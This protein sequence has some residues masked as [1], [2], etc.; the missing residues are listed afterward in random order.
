MLKKIKECNELQQ[1]SY[2]LSKDDATT[3]QIGKASIQVFA[4]MYGG[5]QGYTLNTLRYVKFMEMVS[6]GNITALD[7]QKLPP[8][9]RVAYYHSLRAHL[10]VIIWKKLTG[11][12]LDLKQWGWKLDDTVLIPIMTDLNAAP[13][14]LLKFV[15]CKCKLSSKN[16]C[17]TN[18]CS[19]WKNGLKCVTACED[20]Q[21]E[22]CKNA[23]EII[24]K[25]DNFNA[26]EESF[27]L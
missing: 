5:K 10:Q 18:T 7:P 24:D 17:G 1:I 16:P 14:S 15:L 19:C 20:C 3:E 26:E 8:T 21:G 23:E 13:E 25:E 2:V 4:I 6:S 12:D 11:N 9:E 22:G 27:D